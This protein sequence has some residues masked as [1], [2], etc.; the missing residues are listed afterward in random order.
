MYSVS[1]ES[2]SQWIWLIYLCMVLAMSPVSSSCATNQQYEI[3]CVNRQDW[4]HFIPKVR[5]E[6][7]FPKG[8]YSLEVWC[9]VGV[10]LL[11]FFNHLY[12]TRIL[13][14]KLLLQLPLTLGVVRRPPLQPSGLI[15][16]RLYA[17]V[18]QPPYFAQQLS[19]GTLSVVAKSGHCP[20]VIFGLS[21]L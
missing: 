2:K 1:V 6:T 19:C 16:F 21:G 11:L 12:P 4:Y 15:S 7:I 20:C 10:L 5:L 18:P 17:K 13:E 14:D 8:L 9:N 3:F